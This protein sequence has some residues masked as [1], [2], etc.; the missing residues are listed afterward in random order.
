MNVLSLFDGM[1]CGQIALNQLGIEYENYF[2]SEIDPHAIKVTQHNYPN[3]KQIGSVTEVKGKDL[4]KIDLL[5]GGS[6][7]QGFSFAGKQ[8]NFDDPRSVLFFEFVR[9]LKET[10]PTFFLLENVN[11]KQ[12]FQDVI[13]D[14]LGINPIRINSAL[15]S[16]ANR[17]RLYWTNI[18]N[19]DQPEDKGIYLKD[20]LEELPYGIGID[21]ELK[22]SFYRPTKG[23]KGIITLNPDGVKHRQ[24]FQRGRVYDVEG[25]SPAMCCSI[26][27]FKISKDHKHYRYLTLSE[28]EKLHGVPDGYT[29]ILSK[30][31]RG[32]V[33]G[34]GWSVDVIAHIFKD[35][36][37][38]I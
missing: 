24:T 30:A 29:K 8:L 5:F 31:K 34:N 9:I 20:I 21:R 4:P 15:L 38:L 22:H 26:Y 27:A 12:E 7:C 14:L 28:C 25:K 6:P 35:L 23:S 36:D 16:A 10:K 18:P 3:T 33:L 11:M 2:A 17:D 19:V 37:I 13:S 1:S 32:E